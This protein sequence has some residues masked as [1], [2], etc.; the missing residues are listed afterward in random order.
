MTPIRH[1]L[2]LSVNYEG[3]LK[4]TEVFHLEPQKF[5]VLVEMDLG[6]HV[7]PKPVKNSKLQRFF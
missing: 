4:R 2:K 5:K 1:L 3:G 6:L 7:L